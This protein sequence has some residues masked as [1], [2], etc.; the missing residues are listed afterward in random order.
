MI[1]SEAELLSYNN[2]IVWGPQNLWEERTKILQGKFD[3]DEGWFFIYDIFLLL[4]V[5]FCCELVLSI[6]QSSDFF[7][8]E[9]LRRPLLTPS[10]QTSLLTYQYSMYAEVTKRTSVYDCTVF[11][12][13]KMLLEIFLLFAKILCIITKYK[14]N[15]YKVLCGRCCHRTPFKLICYRMINTPSSEL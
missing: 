14:Y 4:V 11:I 9:Y 2:L 3:F 7:N 13:Y 12:L 6:H 8:N 1:T 10:C 5:H 15:I